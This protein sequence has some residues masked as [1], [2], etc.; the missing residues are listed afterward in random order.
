MVDVIPEARHRVFEVTRG[1]VAPG[2]RS[3][4][5]G[6]MHEGSWKSWSLLAALGV[7]KLA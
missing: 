1:Q 3:L 4:L 6:N 7:V 5:G 2:A